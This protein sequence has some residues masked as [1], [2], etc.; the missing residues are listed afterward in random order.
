[1]FN[2]IVNNFYQIG[3]DW[4][5]IDLKIIA[6]KLLMDCSLS[7]FKYLFSFYFNLLDII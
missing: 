2:N 4:N 3:L 7:I 1:M 5:K 6:Q